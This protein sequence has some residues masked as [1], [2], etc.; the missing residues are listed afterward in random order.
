MNR[1]DKV[2]I[3][4]V[5]FGVALVLGVVVWACHKQDDCD[6]RGGTLIQMKCLDIKEL[7]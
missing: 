4:A 1:D 5:I 3:L 2:A 6:K 7:K